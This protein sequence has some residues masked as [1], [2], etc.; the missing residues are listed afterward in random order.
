LQKGKKSAAAEKG[1]QGL[2][3]YKRGKKREPAIR[4]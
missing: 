2:T 3:G 1:D 4:A